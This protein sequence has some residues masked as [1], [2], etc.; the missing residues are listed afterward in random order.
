MHIRDYLA[1]PDLLSLLNA[2]A[3]FLSILMLLNGNYIFS[4]QFML[5][6]VIFDSL[7]GWVARKTKRDDQFGFGKNMDSLSDVISFGVAPGMFLCVASSSMFLPYINIVVGLL[8]LICGILRLSRFNVL[9]NDNDIIARDKFVGLP[10]P[11]TAMVLGSFYLSGIFS[12][13]LALLIMVVIAVLMISTIEYPKFKGIKFV[14]IG[15]LLIIASCLPQG[16][17]SL[18]AYL[19]A[20]LL[21][22]FTSIYVI[23]VPLME[24]YGKLLRSGPH[25]R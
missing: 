23:I 20:K 4:A 11:T 22:V 9:T 17:M 25:V 7:D 18:I 16:I 1:A 19:P 14:V 13:N 5:L 21:L 10:I 3:G 8:I 12:A 6:A 24:L 2:S 15:G